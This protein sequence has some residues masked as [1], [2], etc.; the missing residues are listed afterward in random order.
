MSETYQADLVIKNLRDK[1]GI[2]T[3]EEGLKKYAKLNGEEKLLNIRNGK[4]DFT[5]IEKLASE[6][7]EKT[8]K[9]VEDITSD[10]TFKPDF[11]LQRKTT[12]IAAGILFG[13]LAIVTFLK[14]NLITG[15]AISEQIPDSTF[16]LTFVVLVVAIIALLVYRWK[17][18][19]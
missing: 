2:S 5:S 6:I 11:Y 18:C 3:K 8:G 16:S 12:G 10:L 19:K 13:V 15:L 1:Y 17:C 9:K 7:S 14:S 4:I